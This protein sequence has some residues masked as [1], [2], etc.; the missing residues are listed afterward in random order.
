MTSLLFAAD[1]AVKEMRL[2]VIDSN[3]LCE[4][5]ALER[6]TASY[7]TLKVPAFMLGLKAEIPRHGV[8][9]ESP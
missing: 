6:V 4:T 2:I 9:P 8:C 1:V 5:E 7:C 3:A